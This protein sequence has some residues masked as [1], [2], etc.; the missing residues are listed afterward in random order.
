VN[1]SPGEWLI[2]TDELHRLIDRLAGQTRV[3]APVEH[4]AAVH[5]RPIRGSQEIAWDY[6]LTLLPPSKL[7]FAPRQ[8]MVRSTR[9]ADGVLHTSGVAPDPTPTV[10]LAVHPCDLHGIA[11]LER[12]LLGPDEDPWYRADR[13]QTTIVGLNC[14]EPGDLCFCASYGTGPFYEQWMGQGPPE[15]CDLLLTNLG[16]EYL[17]EVMSPRGEALLGDVSLRRA[18]DPARQRKEALRRRALGRFTKRLDTEGLPELLMA[19]LDHPVWERV[20]EGRCLSCT[21]CT[22]VCPTCYCYSVADEASLDL[23]TIRRWRRWDSCQDQHFARISFANPRGTRKARLRQFVCH[24]LSYWVPQHGCFGCVGC[25]RC[26]YWCPT[27]IDL[28][29]IAAEIRRDGEAAA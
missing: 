10:L 4:D 1:A 12:T 9:D 8:E 16:Q 21:N 24:K 17:A 3:L 19:H 20:G 22:M 28:T 23:A 15:G 7:I 11:V 18:D 2:G 26:I 29:E 13:E 5:F 14:R 6:T 27:K 25:A